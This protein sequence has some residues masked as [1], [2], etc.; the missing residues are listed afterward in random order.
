MSMNPQPDESTGDPSLRTYTLHNYQPYNSAVDQVVQQHMLL[1]ASLRASNREVVLRQ[2]LLVISVLMLACLLAALIYWLLFTGSV[3]QTASDVTPA[4]VQE[5]TEISA[6]N[7][8]NRIGGFKS[9]VQ[10]TEAY[11]SSGEIVV[12]GRKYD[13]ENFDA[14]IN[15][16]CYL[17]ASTSTTNSIDIELAT[18]GDDGLIVSQTTDPRLLGEPLG[19]CDFIVD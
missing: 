2:V 19:L 6:N 16:W 15:Q 4:P 11:T 9:F 7:P 12:T 8:S 13:V 17:T 10:F 18:I 5:L 3:R 14:P 1:T